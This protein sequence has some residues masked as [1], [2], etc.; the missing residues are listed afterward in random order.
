MNI[1]LIGYR[2]SGKTS[3]GRELARLLGR[4][5]FRHGPDDLRENG[6]VH[7]R[8]RR[9]KRMAGLPRSGE[10][11]H[12]GAFPSRR[13]RHRVRGRRRHGPRK[14]GDAQGRGPV[15]LASGRREDPGPSNE[16]G[17]KR[18]GAASLAHRGRLACGDRRG[19]GEA[20]AGLPGRCRCGHRH[21]GKRPDEDCGRDRRAPGRRIDGQGNKKS[22]EDG[23]MSGNTFG[24]LFRVTTFGGIPRNGPRGRHRRLPAR[25]SISAR[26]TS[27]RSSTGAG[28][29]APVGQSPPRKRK[30]GS[31]SSPASSR[32]RR[33]ERRSRCSSAT[34]MPTA[35][36]MTTSATSSVPA[37][38]TITYQ[39]KYGIRDHRGGGRASGRE[40]A[41][42][43]AAGAV[44]RKVIAQRGSTSS[45]CT[46]ELGGIAAETSLR[47]RSAANRLL[48]PRSGGGRRMELK[49]S[50][51]RGPRA[52][53]S[54]GSWR[55]SSGAAR[56]GWASRSST[57]STRI[58]PGP[59]W[60]SGPSRGSRSAPGFA[61]AR[62][63]GSA[64]ATIPSVPAGF[65]TNHAGGILAGITTGQEI[66]IRVGLQAHP[67]HRPAAGD[68]RRPGK[69]AVVAIEGRHDASVI[70][71]I[72][73]VCEAMVCLVLADHLLRQRA[74]R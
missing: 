21:G 73:P 65:R 44:A 2:A 57:R 29:A 15:R 7:P 24:V 48:L 1:I 55:S 40:T 31:R 32:G 14:R 26:P 4:P 10:N 22:G 64:T 33:R 36:P 34:A 67:L 63:N 69:P 49:G 62:M 47:T 23:P 72:I 43:V 30:T 19:P 51:R 13:G 39:A 8:D 28:R 71:R 27:R 41:A 17:S 45:A 16:P 6:Q 58:W 25:T 70:P 61:A 5:F 18:R 46:V 56:P 59:S 66:V 60:G 38:G 68:D 12:L 50:K 20:P 53:R 11:G 54:A 35:P 52:T 74:V 9:G 42:R 3:A 37:T